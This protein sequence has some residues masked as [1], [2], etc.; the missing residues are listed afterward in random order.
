M[1]QKTLG[2]VAL[3]LVLAAL[4]VWIFRRSS[5]RPKINLNPYQALGAVAGEE[6]SKLL[7]Q[8][9]EII[10]VIPDPGSDRDPVMDAQLAAFH[11]ELKKAGKVIVRS[12][13]TVKMDPFQSMRTGGA[14]PS[15]QFLGLLKK[16]AGV[17]AVVLFLGFP[18]LGNEDIAE[19]KTCSTKRIVI[20]AAIP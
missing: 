7:G 9:G 3:V 13:E 11:K 10:I 1:S 16:H 8:Q 2:Q 6:T 4:S 20:S 17:A 19:L 14:M 5:D 15:E 18:A 12:T